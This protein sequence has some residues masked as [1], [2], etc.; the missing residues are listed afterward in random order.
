MK[1]WFIW[2]FLVTN[3]VVAETQ[4]TWPDLQKNID[5]WIDSP[6]SLLLTDQERDVY[7]K[8][9]TPEDKMQFIRIFWAR[10]DP[11]LRTREN[12]FKQEFYARV[13]AAD[14]RFAEGKVPGWKTARGQVYILFGP[15]S[16]EEKRAIPESSRPALFWIYDRIGSSRIPSNEALVFVYRDIKYVLLPPSAQ[17]GD[18]IGAEMRGQELSTLG[19]QSIPSVVQQAFADVTQKDIVDDKKDYRNLLSSVTTTEKFDLVG[20]EFEVVKVQDN[21][22][23]FKLTLSKEAAPIYDAGTKLFLELSV[24]QELRMGTT[25]VASNHKTVSLEWD[26]RTFT[27]LGAIEIQLPALEVAAGKG[28]LSVTVRDS[29]SNISETRKFPVGE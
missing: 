7:K 9:S 12:E 29:V 25:V 19:Y 22:L 26:Q 17:E 18:V 11:L 4:L 14:E 24:D 3:I 8:L 1:K 27:G 23:Q 13:D 10:R 28:E 15:P 6:V 5:S 2:F 16:R 21:P 20:I